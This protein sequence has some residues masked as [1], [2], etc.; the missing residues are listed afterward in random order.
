MF[1]WIGDAFHHIAIGI[2]G[3]LIVFAGFLAPSISTTTAPIITDDTTTTS[4]TVSTSTTINEIT[5]I[6]SPK[7]ETPVKVVPKITTPPTS[8]PSP[9]V[10]NT[11]VIVS[12][13][14]AIPSTFTTTI[15]WT[16]NIKSDGKLTYWAKIG[17]L[18]KVT[19]TTTSTINH[20]VE[21]PTFQNTTY[22]YVV[23]VNAPNGTT[24]AS[25]QK[26]FTSL[27]DGNT[28]GITSVIVTS[29]QDGS[30]NLT[31]NTSEP[32]QITLD[33]KY[34]NTSPAEITNTTLIK[35]DF[36]NQASFN[37]KAP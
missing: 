23:E 6:N 35:T 31:I 2:S 21:V 19:K 17:G 36:S 22:E 13:V 34:F 9:A 11:P 26:E 33:Y 24:A 20:E 15:S 25:E 12:N 10:D 27:M 7:T 1:G 8:T 5:Q 14:R 3:I 32:S 29:G 4:A 18:N 28:P 16:T 37:V 30:I